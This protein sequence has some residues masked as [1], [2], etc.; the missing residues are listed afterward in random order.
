MADQ[1]K[2]INR[3]TLE[4]PRLMSSDPYTTKSGLAIKWDNDITP[5]EWLALLREALDA[6]YEHEAQK[7]RINSG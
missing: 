1:E 7:L 3:I 5:E 6:I 2:N 4:G